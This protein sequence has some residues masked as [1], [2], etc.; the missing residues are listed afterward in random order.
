MC[1][2]IFVIVWA[3]VLNCKKA[4]AITCKE[5]FKI[6][7]FRCRPN[8]NKYDRDYVYV[9]AMSSLRDPG[10]VYGQ[11]KEWT[12]IWA[13]GELVFRMVSHDYNSCNS[14]SHSLVTSFVKYL[15]FKRFILLVSS[16]SENM[17][18][19]REYIECVRTEY[20]WVRTEI[21][22]EHESCFVSAIILIPSLTWHM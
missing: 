8:T 20:E 7:N 16:A 13:F 5:S 11:F 19:Q 17:L 6:T 1:I 22:S 10:E 3:K 21:F 12:N 4:L 18:V 14:D 2:H 15:F 9:F